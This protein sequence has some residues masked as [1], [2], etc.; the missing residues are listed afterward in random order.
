[1]ENILVIPVIVPLLFAIGIMTIC[2]T[3]ERQRFFALAA[4]AMNVLV[5]VTLLARTSNGEILVL[6][7]GNWPAPYG[8]VLVADQLA[9]LMVMMASILSLCIT[10]FVMRGL[11]ERR[12]RRFFH[13]LTQFLMMGVNMSLVTG[14]LF[15]LFVSFE[16]MLLASYGLMSLA[17]PRQRLAPAYAY[18]V[19]NVVAGLIFLT[20][21][22]LT[23]GL[24]GTLNMADM[25]VKVRALD[26]EQ[27]SKLMV[28]VLLMLIVF[29]AKAAMFPLFFWLPHGYGAA[30]T[31]IVAL[32]AGLLTKV[33]VYAMI[34]VLAGVFEPVFIGIQP[35]VLTL[36][37]FTMVLGVLGAVAQHTI[38]RILSFHIVSQIGYMIMGVAL[39]TP[40]TI[41]GAVFFMLHNMMVKTGLILV[42]GI[43]EMRRGTDDLNKLGGLLKSDT[44]LAVCFFLLAM[45]LAGLPPLT[46]FWGKYLL[47]EAGFVA[48]AWIIVTVS[49]MTSILTL[50]SMLKIWNYAF[51]K[52]APEPPAH[53]PTHAIVTPAITQPGPAQWVPLLTLV[54]LATGLGF[55]PEQFIL[56]TRQA[57]AEVLDKDRYYTE[58]I[59]N[60][61]HI[62]QGT[63]RLVSVIGASELVIPEFIPEGALI[64]G[65][66]APIMPSPI[67]QAQRPAPSQSP[68][69]PAASTLE[70]EPQL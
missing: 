37:G 30:T 46:G 66:E 20:A 29:G 16:V 28:I 52:K 60:Q 70:E 36:A 25:A 54:I 65:N 53:D 26:P 23:Y 1:M 6:R 19:L 13:P 55:L 24:L 27:Q 62:Y 47:I 2:R 43:V 58:V 40:H 10:L 44:W 38:R 11:N 34:R 14:D 15:N 7:L 18:L 48:E 41:A 64:V 61:Q 8:I 68:H 67:P 50:F 22:G 33:G 59:G 57:G 31:P 39:L 56:A 9:A 12:E 51:W 5:A 45:S 69:D 4:C 42:G 63:R 49:I 35:L 17:A 21:V 3:L 32:F